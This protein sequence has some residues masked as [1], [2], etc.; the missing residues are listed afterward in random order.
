M[1]I[2]ERVGGTTYP[3]KVLREKRARFSFREKKRKHW[4]KRVEKKRDAAGRGNLA[5][6]SKR[7]KD[8]KTFI[9]VKKVVGDQKE[10]V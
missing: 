3:W 8:R 2:R 6:K 7:E 5:I 10:E 4:R 9:D 1:S